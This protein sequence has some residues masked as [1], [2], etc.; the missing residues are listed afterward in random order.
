MLDGITEETFDTSFAHY[1]AQSQST[2]KRFL[3]PEWSARALSELIDLTNNYNIA[4]I[5]FINA[6]EKAFS[7]LQDAKVTNVVFAGIAEVETIG[8]LESPDS[9]EK[10][11]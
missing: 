2:G 8:L 11:S 4:A 10:V 7:F 1:L 3:T 5:N 9:V 6:G